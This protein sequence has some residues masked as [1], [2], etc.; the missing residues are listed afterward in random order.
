MVYSPAKSMLDNLKLRVYDVLV[1]VEDDKPFERALAAGLMI[2]ILLNVVAVVLESVD[3]IR[4]E[5]GTYFDWFEGVSVAVF[6]VEYLL[7]LWVSSV[8]EKF[9]GRIVG[10]L[11]Y[12]L[13]P[14]AIIDLLAILPA[15]LPLIFAFDLRIMR[16]LRLFRLF[17][18]LK[19]ARYVHSLDSLH[20]VLNAKKETLLVTTVLISIKLLFASSLMYVLENEVQPDKFPDIP[21]A[22]WWGIATLTTVGYGDV[23]PIT[24]AGKLLGGSIAFLGIGLFALPAGIIASGFAE[25][26][27][28]RRAKAGTAKACPHC[29]EQI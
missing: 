11:R 9:R 14:M 10:R 25:E 15:F 6:S 29:G 21:S 7:R 17:R 28:R 5:Y 16:V 3:S 27:E 19:M 4:A 26:V 13:T 18:L 8:D 2:L 1:D 23:Y 20:R 22:L 12:A 24:G